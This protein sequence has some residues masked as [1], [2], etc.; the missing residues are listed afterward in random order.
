MRVG[1]LMNGKAE[2]KDEFTGEM[3][4]G[5]GDWVVDRIWRLCNMACESGVVSEDW[6]SAVVVPLYKCKGER[7][8]CE[9]YRGISLS[10]VGKIYT[11][12]LVDRVRRVTGGLID[13]EQGSFKV[14]KGCLS[15]LH[16]KADW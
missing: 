12:I 16:T 5:G 11:E 2:G 7:I 10:V 13:S 15:D 9:N 6:R 1:K 14:G 4:K 8:E 3:I